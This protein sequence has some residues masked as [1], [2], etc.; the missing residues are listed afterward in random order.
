MTIPFLL[1][2]LLVVLILL[3]LMMLVMVLLVLVLLLLLLHHHGY[4][5]RW[6]HQNAHL[7]LPRP[8]PS[9]LRQLLLEKKPISNKVLAL[10]S[11]R[12]SL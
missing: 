9:Q 10:S 11:I 5:S 6:V 2:L 7:D 3:L 1:V 4:Q 12:K 8:K